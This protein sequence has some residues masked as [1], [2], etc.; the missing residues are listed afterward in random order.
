[1]LHESLQDK[2]SLS[3][4]CTAKWPDFFSPTIFIEQ[5]AMPFS[6][7][8]ETIETTMM[9]AVPF[10]QNK[11]CDP[12]YQNQKLVSLTMHQ[13]SF[14]CDYRHVSGKATV[15]VAQILER[16]LSAFLK[17]I[18]NLASEA[19]AIAE[20]RDTRHKTWKIETLGRRELIYLWRTRACCTAI[21]VQVPNLFHIAKDNEMNL[22][23]SRPTP[24]HRLNICHVK[25][26]TP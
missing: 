24:H 7:F 5:F 12:P 6:P 10:T 23:L 3:K 19:T 21:N 8:P 14:V 18:A 26:E 25:N 4:F 20:P 17:H 16:P 1:M 9:L 13:Q 11:A 2:D 15:T 22:I